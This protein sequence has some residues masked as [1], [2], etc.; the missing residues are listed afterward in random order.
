MEVAKKLIELGAGPNFPASVGTK[1]TAMHF[2]AR[3]VE[4]H[5]SAEPVVKASV[6]AAVQMLQLLALHGGRPDLT[7]AS[8]VSVHDLVVKVSPLA[9]P[10]LSGK[11][12]EGSSTLQAFIAACVEQYKGHVPLTIVDEKGD[13]LP[14]CPRDEWTDDSE[15]E[16]CPQCCATFSLAVRRHHCRNC[17]CL[18]CAACSGKLAVMGKEVALPKS[19]RASFSFRSNKATE[20]RVCD[21][22]FNLLRYKYVSGA[23]GLS[24][25]MPM[26]LEEHEE[27]TV[28]LD[29]VPPGAS[30]P[31]LSV[32]IQRARNLKPFMGVS[33]NAHPYAMVSVGQ[34]HHC[35]EPAVGDDFGAPTWSLGQMV[36]G[37]PAT[38][39]RP[40]EVD[41]DDD[42]VD[43]D[44]ARSVAEA[45]HL[46]VDVHADGVVIGSVS[47]PL[48]FVRS[49]TS[50]FVMDGW[51][52]LTFRGEGA[53][54][55]YLR[56]EEMG[57]AASEGH[58]AAATRVHQ[59]LRVWV[60]EGKDLLAAD[61]DGMSDPYIIARVGKRECYK[62]TVV[63]STLNP[64][65]GETGAVFT[66]AEGE[67]QRL[68]Q[69]VLEAATVDLEVWDRDILKPDDPLG[70]VSIP[71]DEVRAASFQAVEAWHPVVLKG[72]QHGEVRVRLQ[73]LPPPPVEPAHVEVAVE[74][75]APAPAAAAPVPAP[76][77]AAG[78]TP[79]PTGS[80]QGLI[81]EERA[82][83]QQRG[84]D[85][86]QPAGNVSGDATAS[87]RAAEEQKKAQQ[88]S[89]GCCVVM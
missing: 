74:G 60:L 41:S 34:E 23:K 75:A 17:G 1:A 10:H 82:A 36:F 38:R 28:V 12:L 48:G 69:C 3:G 55:V 50:H 42:E 18:V 24:E 54:E 11:D 40:S 47:V 87:A 46:K 62:S 8:G 39:R 37:L 20:E 26:T 80:V 2:A 33:L 70:S 72:V 58:S 89:K 43:G 64:V 57:S 31:P 45:T 63:P 4:H 32:S 30:R 53:G 5:L 21:A 35:T 52:S 68:Q 71:L 51:R 29:P 22:C 78:A 27:D 15:L 19:P 86:G 56:I 49:S 7:D 59:P 9:T 81:Q 88:A 6:V 16:F 44:T 84:V 67:S 85:V 77:A 83:L 73:L 76:A 65:W 14:M 61:Y 25:P 66:F 79:V 13:P